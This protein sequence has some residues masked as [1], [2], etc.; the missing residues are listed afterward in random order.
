MH[1]AEQLV[2]LI[3][4]EPM[5]MR[6]TTHDA[7][8]EREIIGEET[9]E[10]VLRG[11]DGALSDKNFAGRRDFSTP[12]RRPAFGTPPGAHRTGNAS[13][14]KVPAHPQGP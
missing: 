13:G 5:A 2:G 7:F 14:M 4:G 3:V 12:P 11:R 10:I 6:D 8:E 1:R 9:L